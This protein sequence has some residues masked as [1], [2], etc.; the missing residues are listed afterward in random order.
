MNKVIKISILCCFL[1]IGIAYGN[2]QSNIKES[3]IGGF[4]FTAALLKE[5]QL[6]KLYGKGC[7]DKDYPHHYR[8]I[9]YFPDEDIYGAFNVETDKLIP[10][11]EL[12]RESITSKKC[13]SKKRLKTFKTGQ[14]L[15]LGDREAK[16]LQLYGKPAQK[17]RKSN[18][19][20]YEYYTGQEDGPF[21]TIKIQDGQV[22]SI[23]L[24]V[25]S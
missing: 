11:L 12:T 22:R 18:L 9:Y 3:R 25:G 21:M 5:R 6:I 20:I 7:A 8:R 15:S 19:V 24:T 13:T 1:A 10:G 23:Y 17:T 14:G 16:V 4:D 2:D